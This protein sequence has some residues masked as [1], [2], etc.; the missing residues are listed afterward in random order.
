MRELRLATFPY[1][2]GYDANSYCEFHMGSLRHTI[3]NYYA[4]QDRMQDLIEFKVVTFTPT[5]PNVKTNHMP[6]HEGALF[7]AIEEVEE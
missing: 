6:T 7:S 4:F 1:P 5:C 3:E 2:P